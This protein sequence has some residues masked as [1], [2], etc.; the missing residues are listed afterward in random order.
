MDRPINFEA[1]KTAKA[2]ISSMAKAK[3]NIH[4]LIKWIEYHFDCEVK[5][6]Y[7][8]FDDR[9]CSGLVYEDSRFPNN[10]KIIYKIWVNKNEYWKRQ[11]FTICHELAHILQ[12]YGSV[13]GFLKGDIETSS[14]VERFCNRFAAAYLMPAEHFI[15][16]WNV[17]DD[18]LAIKKLKVAHVFKVS[19]EAVHYRASELGL[20]KT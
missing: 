19:F 13:Y 20:L 4:N 1:E 5:I 14:G 17:L 8:D 6:G 15:R 7:S 10:G 2:I 9:P 12:G 16:R 3:P 11:R 18:E